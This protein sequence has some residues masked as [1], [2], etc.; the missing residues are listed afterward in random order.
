MTLNLQNPKTAAQEEADI[1]D[2]HSN[3]FSV[4]ITVKNRL[5]GKL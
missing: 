2:K 4:P 3:L 1:S 5:A